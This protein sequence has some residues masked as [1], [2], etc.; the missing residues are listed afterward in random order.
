MNEF[1]GSPHLLPPCP[2]PAPSITFVWGKDLTP[3]LMERLR[4]GEV[5]RG[6]D[7]N[8]NVVRDLI[9]DYFGT[10]RECQDALIPK[11]TE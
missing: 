1:K 6:V 2:L 4:N 8:G 9:M 11:E 7:E 3:D 5:I 10:I